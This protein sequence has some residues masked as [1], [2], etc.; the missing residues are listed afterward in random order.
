M[1]GDDRGMSEFEQR[2]RQLL[3][4]SSERLPAAVRSRLTQ[5]RYAALAAQASEPP[6]PALRRWIP[7]GALAAVVL[8]VFVVLAPHGTGTPARIAM[9]GAQFEDIDMLTDSDA[10][11]LNGD[12]DVDYDFYEWAAGEAAG[13]SGPTVGS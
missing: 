9:N 11:S 7:A 10:V 1:S 3:R 6:H 12:Q 13:N 8:A 5:A 2:T 4:E